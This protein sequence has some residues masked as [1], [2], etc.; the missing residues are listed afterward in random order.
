MA[1]EGWRENI[2]ATVFGGVG[3]DQ[4][5]AYSDIDWIDSE[6]VG[7]AFPYRWKRDRP[8]VVVEGPKGTMTVA[9]ID[10]GPWNIHDHKYVIDGERPLAEKQ[11]ESGLEAQNG[12]IPNND[13]G[14]DL[15]P[16]VAKRVGVSGKGKVRWRFA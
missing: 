10:V 14:I 16:P 13:A 8:R 7:V 15:T 6:T 11:Y 2:T 4:D 5:S 12:Q 9:V 3:D 1:G